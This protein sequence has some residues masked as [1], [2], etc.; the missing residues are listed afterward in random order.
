M[1]AREL[2]AAVVAQ[3]DDLGDNP[4]LQRLRTARNAIASR[5]A[6]AEQTLVSERS[7]HVG[8]ARNHLAELI[9]KIDAS[10]RTGALEHMRVIRAAVAPLVT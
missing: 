5:L 1:T 10:T 8:R 2:A 9:A 3:L 4:T 7:I 6:D